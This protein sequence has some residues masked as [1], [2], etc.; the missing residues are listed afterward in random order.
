MRIGLVALAAM[1]LVALAASP[2]P[3][4]AGSIGFDGRTIFEGVFFQSG[5]ACA[6]IQSTCPALTSG[7]RTA[8]SRLEGSVA[9]IDKGFFANFACEMT[10]NDPGIVSKAMHR[11]LADIRRVASVR[12]EPDRTAEV[13]NA[14]G[15]VS[16]AVVRPP[17][18]DIV[19][20][21]LDIGV[22]NT[23]IAIDP[24]LRAAM[25]GRL[26][27]ISSF[28]TDRVVAR[29]TSVLGSR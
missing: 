28:A 2:Q 3:A 11:G 14:A 16:D 5:A 19:V 10:S 23:Q 1:V 25:R 24:H 6:A 26:A 15:L 17:A 13:D 21:V 20:I 12:S 9:R 7:E 27:P 22:V 18:T 29:I 4:L 8:V